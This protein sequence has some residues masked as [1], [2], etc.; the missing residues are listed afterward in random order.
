MGQ[1]TLQSDVTGTVWKVE[2]GE[3]DLVSEE[4]SLLIVES[5]KMEIPVNAPV[6]GT[7]VRVLVREGDAIAEGQDVVII[8]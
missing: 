6:A 2:V 8:G 7:V 1:T 4:Q 5:M 3:G